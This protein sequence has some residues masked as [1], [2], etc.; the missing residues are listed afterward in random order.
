[1]LGGRPGRTVRARPARRGVSI[2]LVG[3]VHHPEGEYVFDVET[4]SEA[5]D[6]LIER[7]AGERS[8]ANAAADE[9]RTSE[10]RHAARVREEHREAW[11]E[12]FARLASSLR[13]SADMYDKRAE[14]LRDRK[15]AT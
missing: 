6:R 12:Y 5:L 9:W 7:R 1:M 14:S 8:A 3:R 10:R 2:S 11:V 4:A 15:E 13:K